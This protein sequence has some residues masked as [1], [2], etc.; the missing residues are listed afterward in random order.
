VSEKDWQ[1][2]AYFV[3]SLLGIAALV[4][5]WTV[6]VRP[7]IETTWGQ[8]TGGE[9]ATLPYLGA[10]DTTDLIGIGVLA[11]PFLVVLLLVRSKLRKARAARRT[12]QEATE[13]PL[14]R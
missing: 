5:I 8:I 12:A 3:A 1:E 7:W 14:Y 11:A 6:Y 9:V 10:F 2:F 4:R 13:R